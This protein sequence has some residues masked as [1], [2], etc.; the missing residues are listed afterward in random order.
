MMREYFILPYAIGVIS[1]LLI[2]YLITGPEHEGKVINGFD[3]IGSFAKTKQI[4]DFEEETGERSYWN[5]AQFGGS[6]VY[7]LKLG[8]ERSVLHV[9]NQGMRNAMSKVWY[10]FFITG[11]FM[12]I[13]LCLLR[14]NPWICLA[15]ASAAMLTTNVHILLVTGHFAKVATLAPLPMLVAGIIAAFRKDYIA[16]F[17]GTFLGSRFC[18]SVTPPANG[19]LYRT[20]LNL[21]RNCSAYTCTS[22]KAMGSCRQSSWR[23][24]ICRYS[25]RIGQLLSFEVFS[26]IC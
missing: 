10:H 21:D 3:T 20:W 6:P 22:R 16:A 9:I 13:A 7:L 4:A 19:V 23:P 15:L 2:S 1:L 24:A 12:Y 14:I 17:A 5:P 8:Q 25:R 11:L 26:G 18:Y